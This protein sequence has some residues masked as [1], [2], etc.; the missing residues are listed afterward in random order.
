MAVAEYGEEVFKAAVQAHRERQSIFAVSPEKQAGSILGSVVVNNNNGACAEAS[1][2]QA[3]NKGACAEASYLQ[4]NNNLQIRLRE[5]L[6]GMA[7]GLTEKEAQDLD[8][9]GYLIRDLRDEKSQAYRV[10]APLQLENPGHN[11]LYELLLGREESARHW[12]RVTRLHTQS[13]VTTEVVRYA[14][15]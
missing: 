15:P 5:H 13:Q 7:D 2:L 12:N 3:N 9:D 14:T 6:D 1:Y 4:G 8:R 11:G 10:S